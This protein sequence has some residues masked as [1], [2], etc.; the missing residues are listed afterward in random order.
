ML[1]SLRTLKNKPFGWGFDGS[2]K[3]S[4]KF[5][6]NS[7]VNQQYP[8][9]LFWQLNLRDALGNIF[10]LIIEY[11][12]LNL[13]LI[14]LFIDYLKKNKLNGYQIFFISIFLVQLFRGVGYINGGF[15]LAFTEIFLTNFIFSNRRKKDYN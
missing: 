3:A 12:Y 10:K 4:N 7:R 2:I 15:V 13:I 6:E 8:K 9:T 1:L 11:G 5:I 14:V